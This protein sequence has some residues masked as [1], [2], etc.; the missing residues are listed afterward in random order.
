MQK[1]VNFTKMIE[2]T[3]EEFEYLEELEAGFN[4]GLPDRLMAMLDNLKN[5]FSGYPISRYEHSL[6]SATRAYQNNEEEDIV[7]AALLHDIGDEIAPHTHGEMVAAI[8]KPFVSDKAAWI[9]KH[10]GVFQ[11]KYMAHKTE[12]EQNARDQ[13]RDHP[14][15]DDCV[16]FCEH[17][18]QNCFDP[19]FKCLPAAFFEPMVRRVF[20]RTPSFQ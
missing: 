3:K 1:V 4:T 20:T 6:Q 17:Y 7:V 11:Q 14:Y 9:V 19:D 10:H 13:Y 15:Y 2:G 8:L 18:D 16:R 12:E 5:S